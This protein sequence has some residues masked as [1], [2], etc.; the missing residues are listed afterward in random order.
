MRFFW[1]IVFCVFLLPYTGCDLRTPSRSA[2]EAATELLAIW[3]FGDTSGISVLFSADAVYADVP[4][5][6]ELV[7]IEQI[8][9]Y[10]THVHSWASDIEIAVQSLRATGE[11]AAIE[12]VMTGVQ[13]RPIRGMIP[14]A[15]DRRFTIQGV[16]LVDVTDGRIHRAVDYIQV[17][18]LIVQLGGYVTLPG[19]GVL[20][21][22]AQN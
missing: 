12:W 7:G 17:L 5:D 3:E 11:S 20:G 22:P 2:E 21:E 8:T 18:P 1:R 6:R 13:D 15:T 16:T 10:V 19:G 4:N 14:M 9:G